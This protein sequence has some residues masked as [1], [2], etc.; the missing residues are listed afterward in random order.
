MYLKYYVKFTYHT[1]SIRSTLH[2][3]IAVSMIERLKVKKD[4]TL[5]HQTTVNRSEDFLRSCNAFKLS[6]AFK[7]VVLSW[8]R[9]KYFYT[10]IKNSGLFVSTET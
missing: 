4:F 10:F 6:T 3:Y 1:V 9:K 2:T 5:V 8:R 7:L